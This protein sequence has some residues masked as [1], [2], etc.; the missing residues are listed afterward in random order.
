MTAEVSIV[1]WFLMIY[2]GSLNGFS[3][4]PAILY[5]LSDRVNMFHCWKAFIKPCLFIWLAGILWGRDS[6]S[7]YLGEYLVDDWLIRLFFFSSASYHLS[8]GL[9][10]CSR[11]SKIAVHCR[12]LRVAHRG[13]LISFV[14]F[15]RHPLRGMLLSHLKK[16]LCPITLLKSLLYFFCS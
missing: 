4:L 8:Y 6:A 5:H 7:D 12:S 1:K 11:T 16:G 10:W 3:I 13:L 14:Q 15:A 2:E 9:G